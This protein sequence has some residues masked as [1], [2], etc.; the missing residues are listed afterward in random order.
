MKILCELTVQY[1][2]SEDKWDKGDRSTRSYK[3]VGEHLGRLLMDE[4]LTD[5]KIKCGGEEFPCHKLILSARSPVFKAMFQAKMKESE[6]MT[7]E[8][9]DIEPAVVTEI[10]HFIY[11]GG[12]KE[13]AFEQFGEEL[14]AAADKYELDSLKDICEDKLS[15]Y[16]LDSSN[17]VRFLLLG[18]RF[19]APMLREK[20]L[21]TVA[22]NMAS[23]VKTDAFRDLKQYPDLLIEIFDAIFD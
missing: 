22:I 6:T 23:I 11:T 20:S 12:I 1:K 14:L 15:Y 4:D 18:D 13:E 16:I 10:L 8:I 19:Q 3:K 9:K 17:A 2:T 5:M 7:V 21:R